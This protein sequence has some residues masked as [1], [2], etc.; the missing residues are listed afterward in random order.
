MLFAGIDYHKRYS[1]VHVMDAV[2]A[3]VKPVES[4]VTRSMEMGVI[5]RPEFQEGGEFVFLLEAV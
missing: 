2:G 3:P 1:V 4:R 5:S